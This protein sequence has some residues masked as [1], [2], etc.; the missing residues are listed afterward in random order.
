ML[1]QE[2]KIMD[3]NKNIGTNKVTNRLMGS[4]DFITTCRSAVLI[5]NNPEE[6]NFKQ[7]LKPYKFY[8]K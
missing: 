2:Y 1:A 4:F 8:I 3:M 7:Q 5:Q 6:K